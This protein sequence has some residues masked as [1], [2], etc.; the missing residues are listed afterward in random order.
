[1][2]LC[3]VYLFDTDA[4]PLGGVPD[5]RRLLGQSGAVAVAAVNLERW[6]RKV[7]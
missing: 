6:K 1:M 5:E 3:E 4:A 7:G 2:G